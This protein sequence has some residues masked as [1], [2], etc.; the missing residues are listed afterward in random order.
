MS[1]L[2]TLAR[3]RNYT[4]AR[5]SFIFN[6]LRELMESEGFKEDAVRTVQ[7][8]EDEVRRKVDENWRIKAEREERT[9]CQST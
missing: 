3:M 2:Q 4:H 5:V 6:N 8:V 9:P 1:V 7:L